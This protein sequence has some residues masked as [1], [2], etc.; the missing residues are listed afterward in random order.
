M[1]GKWKPLK[2]N[3]LQMSL[4]EEAGGVI[5]ASIYGYIYHFQR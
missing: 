1:P 5:M 2:R 3:E 4:Y